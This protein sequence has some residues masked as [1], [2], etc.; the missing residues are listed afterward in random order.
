M[1]GRTLERPPPLNLGGALKK[2]TGDHKLVA[3][4]KRLEREN[5]KLRERLA[6]LKE[7]NHRR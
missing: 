3:E 2:A 5:R 4:V 6:E 1:N 7:R